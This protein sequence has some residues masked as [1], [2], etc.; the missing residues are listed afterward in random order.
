MLKL[1]LGSRFLEYDSG[2]RSFAAKWNKDVFAIDEQGG[3]N[4]RHII[5][6][7]Y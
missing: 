3:D 4:A 6:Q 2:I 7:K 5:A 1:A